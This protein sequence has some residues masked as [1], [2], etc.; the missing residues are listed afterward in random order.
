MKHVIIGAGP[1][2]ITAAEQLRKLDPAAS[3]TVLDGE[4]EA[5]PY[6][7]MAIPYLLSQRIG[8]EGTHLRLDPDHYRTLRID[9]EK[10]RAAAVDPAAGTVRL[11]DGRIVYDGPLANAAA[12]HLESTV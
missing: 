11:A 1:A 2:G 4:G 12:P 7:R 10:T 9:I 3:I 8:E 6:A 5:A